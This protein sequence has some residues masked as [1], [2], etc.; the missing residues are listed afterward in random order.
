MRQSIEITEPKPINGRFDVI[1]ADPPWQY[2]FAET[3]NRA[4]ENHYPTMDLLDIQNLEIPVEDNAVL[5]LWATAPKLVEALEVMQAWG[6]Q[7][8]SQFIWDKEIIGMGYWVRGQHEILLI[9]TKGKFSPP[10][11]ELRVSSVYSEKRN[12]HSQKPE[13]FYNLLESMFPHGKYLELFA[14]RKY[15]EHWEVWGNM[16]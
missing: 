11:P 1:Y 2:D 8:K 15:S 3:E 4:V 9:G 5:Y 7:Y 13:Y 6:F 14:R 12:Q 10:M 16:V